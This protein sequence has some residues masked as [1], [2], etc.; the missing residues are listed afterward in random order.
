M[1]LTSVTK[2]TNTLTQI[3]IV[4]PNSFQSFTEC[5]MWQIRGGRR[6]W[7][8]MTIPWSRPALVN[9]CPHAVRPNP[10]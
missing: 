8:I 6:S 7:M 10:S 1:V 3:P 9:E 5:T 2:P 4:T